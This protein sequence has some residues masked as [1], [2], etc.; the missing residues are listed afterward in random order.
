MQLRSSSGEYLVALVIF[1][2]LMLN[3]PLLSLFN[4]YHLLFGIPAFFVYLFVL[5]A[6]LILL[7]MLVMRTFAD[8]S[9]RDGGRGET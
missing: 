5:W 3:Y 9:G 6:V 7:V 1:G 8:A 4:A 2:M